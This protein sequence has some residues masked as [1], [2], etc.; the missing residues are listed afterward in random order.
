[1]KVANLCILLIASMVLAGCTDITGSSGRSA[2]KRGGTP[3]TSL[4]SADAFLNPIDLDHQHNDL[5]LH[6]VSNHA[7]LVGRIPVGGDGM[8]PGGEGEIDIVG[9]YAYVAIFNFG[10]AIVDLKDPANPKVVGRGQI[11]VPAAG[12]FGHYTADLKV[13]KTGGWVFLALELSPYAGMLIFDAR[14]KTDIKLAGFWASPGKLLGCH[15]I[16]YAEVAGQEYVFCAPLDAAIY[17]GLLSPATAAP[18]REVVTVARWVPAHPVWAS[19]LANGPQTGVSAT[20]LSGHDDMTFQLDPL[21]NKPTLFVSMWGL[22]VWFVDISLPAAPVTLGG[23]IGGGATLFAGNIH[24]TMAFKSEGRRIVVA[25]PEV[26]RP[27]AMFVIDATDFNNPK[28]L[29]EWTALPTFKNAAG[30]D[31]SG[32]FSMHNFQIVDGHVYIAMYHGGIWVIDVHNATRQKAPQ[33]VATYLPH[34]PRADG[35]PYEVGAWDV[36]VWKGYTLTADSNGGFYVLLR[37]GDPAGDAS[38]TS[39][40]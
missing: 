5:S 28:L 25:I 2:A 9:D 15:M 30:T 33:P 29:S 1:M 17:V 10:F 21:T 4:L 24:T 39:F 34:E 31:A 19:Y 32:K 27:P 16:E 18:A 40:A 7:E 8:P 14:E 6:N 13:D 37:A 35:R 36:V 22:G 20:L 23:W 11:P 26:A 3:V 38:Y 12:P